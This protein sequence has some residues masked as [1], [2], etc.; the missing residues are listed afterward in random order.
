[1]PDCV[2]QLIFGD[3]FVAFWDQAN[4]LGRKRPGVNQHILMGFCNK[5]IEGATSR[6]SLRNQQGDEVLLAKNVVKQQLQII[7]FIVINAYKKN[8][9]MPQQIPGQ[10]E[11]G[12]HH[13]EPVGV[14]TSV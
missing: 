1:M 4:G 11:P 10:L 2:M 7:Y 5:P 3:C 9:V 14:E 13:V 6:I 12:I 8:P